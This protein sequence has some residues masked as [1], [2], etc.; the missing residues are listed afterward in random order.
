M[1]ASNSIEDFGVVIERAYYGSRHGKNWCDGEGGILKSKMTRAIKNGEAV[2]NDAKKFADYCKET[3][4]KDNNINRKCNHKRR[5]IIYIRKEDINHRQPVEHV[6]GI[7]TLKGT[8]KL[9]L[10]RT[11]RNGVVMTRR[12]SCFCPSYQ[13]L[14]Y[15]HC[16]NSAYVDK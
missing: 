1:D 14:D 4:S 12:L 6:E 10:V 5:I 13:L 15:N 9:H 16:Q 8:R 11:V 7:E 3:L 2:I